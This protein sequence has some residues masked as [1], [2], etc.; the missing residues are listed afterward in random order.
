MNNL[1]LG[2][3]VVITIVST[4]ALLSAGLTGYISHQSHQDW[5]IERCES[6][7]GCVEEEIGDLVENVAGMRSEITAGFEGLRDDVARLENAIEGGT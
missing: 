2:L 7:I 5:R 4:V 3:P 1:K 6:D